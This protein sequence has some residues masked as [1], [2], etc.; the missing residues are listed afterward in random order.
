[1]APPPTP[2]IVAPTDQPTAEATPPELPTLTPT[3]GLTAVQPLPTST[4][5]N[6][7]GL[8]GAAALGLA[9]VLVGTYRPVK[10]RFGR[11]K[12]DQSGF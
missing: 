11:R 5:G 8:C 10:R 4:P 6:G 7:G 3:D 12:K 9:A 1:L 2:T